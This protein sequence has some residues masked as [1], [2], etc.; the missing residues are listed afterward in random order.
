M[1]RS[2]E[3]DSSNMVE[4]SVYIRG[5]LYPIVHGDDDYTVAWNDEVYFLIGDFPNLT[6][7]TNSVFR[8]RNFWRVM[9]TARKTARARTIH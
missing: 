8:A 6:G 7:S 1:E 4:S 3:K 5:L 2:L 9:R